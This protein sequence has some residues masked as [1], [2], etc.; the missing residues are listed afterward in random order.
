M[1]FLDD[2]VRKPLSRLPEFK[3]GSVTAKFW[4]ELVRVV[5]KNDEDTYKG[6]N[7]AFYRLNTQVQLNLA[8]LCPN[9]ETLTDHTDYLTTAHT[10]CPHVY[11]PP[12]SW[13]FKDYV[14][15]SGCTISGISNTNL[16]YLD[17][18]TK[19]SVFKT[20]VYPADGV[21]SFIFGTNGST[22]VSF[23]NLHIQGYKPGD[24]PLYNLILIKAG[25][26]EVAIRECQ[27][28]SGLI[29]Y[30][31]LDT[32]PQTTRCTDVI[33]RDCTYGY[34]NVRDTTVLGGSC[35][36]NDYN[37]YGNTSY[38]SSFN[39]F[40]TRLEWADYWNIYL[41]R[42][43]SNVFHGVVDSGNKGSIYLENVSNHSFFNIVRRGGRS[44][45]TTDTTNKLTDFYIKNCSSMTFFVNTRSMAA[46]GDIPPT[47]PDYTFIFEGSSAETNNKFITIYGDLTGY[48]VD[49]IK[50]INL[51]PYEFKVLATGYS[52]EDQGFRPDDI[53]RNR[54]LGSAAYLD[55][56]LI[57]A[58][59]KCLAFKQSVNFNTTTDTII[60]FV[61]DINPR[62]Y[63]VDAIVVTNS[64]ISLT[65]AA[66]GLYT[67]PSKT[68]TTLVAS[69]QTYTTLTGS[70]KF[71][72]LTKASGITSDVLTSDT[73][74]LSLTT[75]QGSTAT[76]DVYIFGRILNG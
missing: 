13:Y 69:T 32:Q 44:T 58:G 5:K 46:D 22:A 31:S 34:C 47:T 29:G 50:F 57:T 2:F 42:G 8:E 36:S 55:Y 6:I 39:S 45:D 56:K 48:V 26:D 27:L 19:A 49:A 12:G 63:I 52:T 53:P 71:L 35:I 14:I 51:K 72:E 30:G 68:G 15:P 41:V 17:D 28:D 66:G 20:H 60:P 64:S 25:G 18:T 76:A 24:T 1:G 74:Y 67:G 73:I 38:S 59:T 9:W 7:G 21:A 33:I 3:Q 40:Y 11:L 37:V 10:L 16:S 65:T 23:K 54:D 75:A 4:G 70:S 61:K 43:Q 62:T